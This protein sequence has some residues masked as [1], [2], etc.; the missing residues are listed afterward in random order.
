MSVAEAVAHESQLDR[1]I[2]ELHAIGGCVKTVRSI[3]M[4]DRNWDAEAEVDLCLGMYLRNI[5]EHYPD[6]ITSKHI[7]PLEAI[8]GP[9]DGPR[10]DAPPVAVVGAGPSLDANAEYLRR[11]PGLILTTDRAARA[12]VA[13]RIHLDAVIAVDPRPYHIAK[14]LSYP[15]NRDQV[16]IASVLLDPEA[17]KAWRGK[18]FYTSHQNPG[19]QFFDYGLPSL[20]P[21]MPGLY[22]LGNV[23]N[24]GVQ[25]AAYMGAGKI[26]LVGQDYGYTGSKWSADSWDFQADNDKATCSTVRWKRLEVDHKRELERRTGKVTVPGV[27]G[28]VE[29]Y[30]PYLSYR[31]SLMNLVE[32]WKLD[33][34]N[35]TEGGILTDL[36]QVSLKNAIDDLSRNFKAEDARAR[37]RQAIGG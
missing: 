34:I 20:F 35:A 2:E 5:A 25:V 37:F 22:A 6:I 23:G 9:L 27:G 29:T 16:L 17:I 26:V 4:P 7:G 30:L 1:D 3:G 33:V 28:D 11:F 14:M 36:P 15:E 13:R 18:V 31:K 21:G 32:I 24:M 12:L 8:L 10:K 19:T